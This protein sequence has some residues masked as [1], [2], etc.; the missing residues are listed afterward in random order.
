MIQIALNGARKESI[1]PKTTES[2]VASAVAACIKGADSIHFHPRDAEGNETLESIFVEEQIAAL[3]KE[4]SRVPVG[5]STGEWIEPDLNTRLEQISSWKVMPDFVSVNYDEAGAE[6]VTELVTKKG[7]QIEAGLSKLEAAKSF[8]QLFSKGRFR[9]ILMEP[10]EQE[11]ALAFET[12]QKIENHLNDA[13]VRLP[14]LLHGFDKTCW[15]FIKVAFSKN[16]E[17]RI[18]FEDVLIL[19][20]G[21]KAKTNAELL[22][23]ALQL[24]DQLAALATNGL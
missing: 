14:I 16:Y 21:R 23:Q 6:E 3:R 10:Q 9:R 5:I 4:L 12:V 22:V 24:K 1:V 19:P 13:G 18:G 8:G 20:D 17:T 15:E 2:I 11:F 7:I